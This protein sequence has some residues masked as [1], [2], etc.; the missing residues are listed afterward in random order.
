MSAA[1]PS[2]PA[3]QA[4][5]D[6]PAPLTP[7]GEH[8]RGVRYGLSLA[9]VILG[10]YLVMQWFP[11]ALMYAADPV[12]VVQTLV[13]FVLAIGVLLIGLA[14]APTSVARAAIAALLAVGLLVV[15]TTLFSLRLT[16]S[17]LVPVPLARVPVFWSVL[18]P[19][20]AALGS[21]L[22]GWLIVRRR[23][24]LTYVLVL[25]ALLPGLARHLLLMSGVESGVT[26][27]SD[28]VITVVVGVGGAWIAAGFS[29]VLGGGRGSSQTASGQGTPAAGQA[30][31]PER[32]E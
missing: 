29:H 1:V 21:A 17:S 10:V 4:A 24:P 5:P 28:L 32:R 22:L 31:G 27:F 19:G 7:R 9:C 30:A 26:W 11:S 20:T 16:G 12:L 13:Q 25:G 8:R 15:A 18:S 14:F 23:H 3:P 2:L 6:G